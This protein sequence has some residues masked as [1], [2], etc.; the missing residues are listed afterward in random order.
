MNQ[1]ASLYIVVSSAIMI[2]FCLV[3]V[4]TY[5][6]FVAGINDNRTDKDSST[7][8]STQLADVTISNISS[9]VSTLLIP[10]ESISSSF[11]VNNP[12]NVPMCFELLWKDVTNTFANTQDLIVSL[13]EEGTSLALESSTFP[14]V[15]G[16]LKSNLNIPAN[17]SKN[18][19]LTVTYQL[20]DDDQLE[21]RDKEFS[22]TIT[23]RLTNC[24]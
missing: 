6:Y 4:G 22:G 2:L 14:T 21:D 11:A 7:M 23:G 17:S 20:T 1:K 18:Y 16:S 19:K 5:S 8:S 15:E 12:S 9:D 24:Q 10:G 13:E 3:Y